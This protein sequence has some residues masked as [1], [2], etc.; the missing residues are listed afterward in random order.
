[1]SD[2]IESTKSDRNDWHFPDKLIANLICQRVKLLLSFAT[3]VNLMRGD[4]NSSLSFDAQSNNNEQ[5]LC[6]IS[7]SDSILVG[8]ESKYFENVITILSFE[9][10]VAEFAWNKVE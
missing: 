7:A 4:K 1:M 5:N 2:R 9:N 6:W 8:F 3:F 10:S